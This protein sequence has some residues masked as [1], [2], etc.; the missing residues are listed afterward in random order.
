MDSL[1]RRQ[2]LNTLRLRARTTRADLQL[3]QVPI[4]DGLATRI[5]QRLKE[6]VEAYEAAIDDILGADDTCAKAP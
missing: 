5:E 3:L 2:W 6:A 4:G 1:A